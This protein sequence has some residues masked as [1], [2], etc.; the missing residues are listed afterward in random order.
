MEIEIDDHKAIQ[1][2]RNTLTG[3]GDAET[4][5]AEKIFPLVY[6][7][8]RNI[9]SARMQRE[10]ND[11]VLQPT[12]LVNE[13]FMKLVE[14]K[15]ANINSRTHFIAIASVAM[16]RILCDHARARNTQK[17]GGDRKREQLDDIE[18]NEAES[19]MLEALAMSL[20]RLGEFDPRKAAVVRLR[21]LG[22]LNT[23][24]IAETLGV[25]RSTVDADWAAAKDWIREELSS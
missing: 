13:A 21:F 9:A 17:R 15:D 1:T 5:A 11:Q 14:Q 8:L 12:A 6:S 19:E 10:R 3:L 7:E 24:Q 4:R 16:Q 25:A 2:C 20:D 22:G 23:V 18:S